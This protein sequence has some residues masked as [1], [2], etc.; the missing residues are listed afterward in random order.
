MNTPPAHRM[1]TLNSY[2]FWNNKGGVGKS[3]LCFIAS[4]EYARRYPDTDVY[5]ID[6][7]PQG[8]VSETL[9]GGYESSPAILNKLTSS[10]PRKT[11]A[12]YLESRL[13]SPFRQ[14]DD[15]SPYITRPVK[16]N[17]NV[18]DNLYLICGDN[19]LEILSEAIRQ[20][21]QLSIPTDA[22][23]Q[24]IEWVKDLTFALSLRSGDRDSVFMVDCNP[25][26]AIYTQLGL[27]ATRNIVVPFTADDSSRRAIENVVALTYGIGDQHVSAYSR[28]NFSKRAKE[29]QVEVPLLH[30]FVSNR[31]TLYDGQPSRA[32]QAVASTIEKTLERIHQ[33]HRSI[34]ANSGMKPSK[35]FITVPDYHSACIVS[36]MTGTP[37]D[38][39]VAGPR[40]LA[41]VNFVQVNKEPLDRYRAALEK[42]VDAL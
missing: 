2:A 15:V 37:L 19:L 27:A 21:S 10:S 12:G 28:I 17:K 36:A 16:Y 18:P 23:K 22:W 34:F 9:L 1:A 42:F 5:V 38:K 6:L 8:N 14:L 32:F 4:C 24:V 25:S 7:C 33:R 30:T 35:S 31:V 13:S 29:E 40:K 41:G 20:T 3:Y 39:L 11:I 26:F